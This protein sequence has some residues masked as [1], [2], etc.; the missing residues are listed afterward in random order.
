MEISVTAKCIQDH[1][2]DLPLE[3]DELEPDPAA[4]RR[5]EY[6]KLYR[7]RDRFFIRVRAK[8]LCRHRYL[9]SRS[10]NL[11]TREQNRGP[12]STY[13]YRR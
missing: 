13:R 6:A 8:R 12:S 11:G 4:Y 10:G 2:S 1:V 3:A 7:S 5:N 9:F